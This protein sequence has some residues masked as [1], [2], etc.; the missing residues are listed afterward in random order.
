MS[1][2]R[3]SFAE[4]CFAGKFVATSRKGGASPI[5]STGLGL[6]MAE[7]QPSKTKS[8]RVAKHWPRQTSCL[9]NAIH[10]KPSRKAITLYM[11]PDCSCC[12]LCSIWCLAPWNFSVPLT[13]TL[14]NSEGL[15]VMKCCSSIPCMQRRMAKPR[16]LWLIN[17]EKAWKSLCTNAWKFSRNS[18]SVRCNS[19]DRSLFT[20]HILF[21]HLFPFVCY[22]FFFLMCLPFFPPFSFLCVFFSVV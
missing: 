13:E 17:L 1:I 5:S 7:L 11:C 3:K 21:V 4:K 9:V 6:H 8:L 14:V 18:R 19:I 10:H 22:D 16:K 12:F 20:L 15:C 2:S